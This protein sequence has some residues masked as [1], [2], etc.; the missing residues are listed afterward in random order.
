[1]DDAAKKA[2]DFAQTVTTQILTLA[3]AIVGLTVTFLDGKLKAYSS[4]TR[5]LLELGWLAFIVSIVAGVFTLMSLAGNL[6]RPNAGKGAAPSIYAGNI[7]LFATCQV[8]FFLIA[9]GFTI[10]FGWSAA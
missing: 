4:C 7:R 8:V 6:E 5:L 2:F 1:M 10:A 9:L 3:T